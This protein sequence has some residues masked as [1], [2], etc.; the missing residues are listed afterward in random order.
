MN[1]FIPNLWLREHL[2]TSASVDQIAEYLSSCSQ[3]VEKIHQMN[4]ESI[5]EIE[6]TTNRPDC[7][8]VFGIARELGAILPNFNIPANLIPLSSEKINFSKVSNA[9]TLDVNIT[10]KTL[11]PRFT[12]IVFDNV[13]VYPS[14]KVVQERLEKSG[15]RALNNVVDISNYLMLELGQPMHTFD[16]D[17]IGLAKMTL[18]ES[19][20]GESLITLDGQKRELPPK[21]IVIEDGNKKLIDLCGIMGGENSAVDQ[22]TKRVLLFVQTYDPVRI[23]KTC[24]A[25]GFRTDASSRFEKGVDPEGVITAIKRA[26]QLF[27]QNCQATVAGNLIDIYPHPSSKKTVLLTYDKLIKLLG[28][29]IKIK[30]AVSILE[31][32]GFPTIV[33]NRKTIV[34]TVPHWRYEDISISEDLVEEIARVYGYFNLPSE[35]LEGQIPL[36]TQNETDNFTDKIKSALKYWGFSES[37]S[38]SLISKNDL[39][40]LHINPETCLKVSNPISEDWVYLRPTLI[41]SMLKSVAKNQNL[42]FD[43]SLFEIANIYPIVGRNRLPEETPYLIGAITNSDFYKTK[44]IIESLITDLEVNHAE[45]RKYTEKHNYLDEVFQNTQS[46]DLYIENK[47]V[48]CLGKINNQ[49][50]KLFGVKIDLNLF[51]LNKNLLIKHA[52]NNRKFTPIPK[53]PPTIEDLALIVQKNISVGSIVQLIKSVSTLIYGVELIDIYE[54]TRTFRVTYLC[55]EK[56]LKDSE[57]GKIRHDILNNLNKT[58]G[59]S[60]KSINPK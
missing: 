51:Y 59:I 37:H 42:F 9:L 25:L 44:G 4:G 34:S 23:R 36:K 52:T 56:T 19:K 60:L 35:M 48:G 7:L 49:I 40:N 26:V 1:I 28:I 12:A 58:Y 38:Y 54:D 39:E 21:T 53:N 3:S 46:A 15:I 57:T 41:T 32:L 31:K 30:E 43:F 55:P 22:K 45:F 8:S 6:V 16:Y 50:L 10:D 17:K 33:K 14:P 20:K 5:Y 11:C 29:E 47:E 24:Q 13:S 2:K 27:E 18:R